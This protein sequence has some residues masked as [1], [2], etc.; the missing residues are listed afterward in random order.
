[1]HEIVEILWPSLTDIFIPYKNREARADTETGEP[2]TRRSQSAAVGYS[3]DTGGTSFME[4]PIPEGTE[5]Q[6]ASPKSGFFTPEGDFDQWDLLPRSSQD[7]GCSAISLP[8][9]NEGSEFGAL[10][11]TSANSRCS[12][13]VDVASSLRPPFPSFIS[14]PSIT[15]TCSS[16]SSGARS[17]VVCAKH[18]VCVCVCV[19]VYIYEKD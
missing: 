16:T 6:L 17:V 14:S 19:S 8:S 1:M 4:S 7:L 5:E 15:S 10:S 13:S 9:W 2:N 3:R 11:S 18:R 12:F